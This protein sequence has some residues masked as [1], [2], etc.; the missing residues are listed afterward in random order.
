MSRF[1]K[2]DT[3]KKLL[4]SGYSIMVVDED[5]KPML[6]WKKLQK[7]PWTEQELAKQVERANIWRYGLL[8]GFNDLF[9]IDVDLKVFPKVED[10]SSF[11]DE[12]ISFIRDN[13]DSFDK[14]VAIYKTANFGYHLVYRTK[15]SAGNTKLARRKGH[16]QAILE[17]RGV[18]GYIV[19]YDECT[20]G[21]D[22][23]TIQKLTEEEHFMI[24]EICKFYD[25]HTEQLKQD[26]PQEKA[27]LKPNQG[28]SPWADFNSRNTVMD[29]VGSDFEIVRSISSRYIVKRHG[30][31]ASHSGYIYKDSGCLYLFTTG[32][33]YP[34]EKLLSPYALYTHKN[35]S[36]DYSAAAK[37]LYSEGYGDRVV[38]S[39]ERA[40]EPVQ[41]DQASLDFPIGIFPNGIQQYLVE[42]NRTLDSSI[43]YMGVSLIWMLSV[44]IGNSMRVQVKS[45]W[46]EPAIVWISCV[47]KAGLGKTPS[48]DNV[49]RPLIKINSREIR[50]YQ[51]QYAKFKEYDALEAKDKKQ[52]E[53]IREPKKRQFVVNDVTIEALVQLHEENPNAVGVFKD[54]LAGWMKDMN[55]YRA[56]SDLEFWLSSWSNK[57]VA[58][59]RKTVANTYVESPIIPVL[60]GIQP[61]ILS[62]LF[63]VENKDNGFVDRMLLSYPDLYVDTYNENELDEE[64]LNW[65]SDYIL[66]M[67]SD[68]KNVVLRF[69]EEMEVD[70]H[71][72]PMTAEAKKEWSR[73]FND[74]TTRQNSDHENEYMKSMLPKQKS[75]IPRFALLLNA[76][77][78][79]DKEL[80]ILSEISASAMLKAEQLSQ[81]FVAM[82]KKLKI[83]ISQ[84]NKLKDIAAERSKSST[85]EKFAA[86]WLLN[87][88]LNKSEAAEIL[89][90]SRQ[91]INRWIKGIE[92]DKT[93]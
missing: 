54:E 87:P 73:I 55:K 91:T 4:A 30:S 40:D 13:I 48:I 29:V 82:A 28:V 10:R 61:A 32:T 6:S 92:G 90:V 79:Y 20:N 59:N 58:L 53:E 68:V 14:K 33:S 9:C 76:L 44:I 22:Y 7:T 81:Y 16:D 67:Y 52:H 2:F 31:S 24:L 47:G 60:G 49:I 15:N 69:N 75:Y 5:K 83:N 3:G 19:A 78:S 45:G 25:D 89:D 21:M 12:F 38:R 88:D 8:T 57:P 39:I 36:G 23:T 35:H 50:D 51:K 64:L 56:G 66:H 37:Q 43:D 42:C 1:V 27:A 26:Q 41:I 65:Y 77:E 71:I 80:P 74:I 85:Q 84:V 86:M 63:T 34:H 18:G 72:I 70:P 62:E 17:T 46:T 93:A 11:F